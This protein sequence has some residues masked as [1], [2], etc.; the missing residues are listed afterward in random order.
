[1]QQGKRG[2]PGSVMRNT[3]ENLHGW[4]GVRVVGWLE[5]QLLQAQALEEGVQSAYE[6]TEGEAPVTDETLY[7]MELCKVG[8][9]EVLVSEHTID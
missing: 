2:K 4:L 8:P 6:V 5:A 9:I 7:L 1:M 3:P